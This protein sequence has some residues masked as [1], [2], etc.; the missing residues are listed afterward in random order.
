MLRFCLH[1]SGF[2]LIT[3]ERTFFAIFLVSFQDAAYHPPTFAI[4]FIILRYEEMKPLL[5]LVPQCRHGREGATRA[6]SRGTTARHCCPINGGG[7]EV[8]ARVRL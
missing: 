4:A 1:P 6:H 2:G 8:F 7:Q 3:E 5:A